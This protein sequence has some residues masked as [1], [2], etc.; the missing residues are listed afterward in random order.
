MNFHQKPNIFVSKVALKVEDIE[1]SI[2]FYE[3]VI[4]FELL[5]RTKSI[6][7]LTADGETPLLEI[8]QPEYVTKKTGQTTGL[9][10][11]AL[12]LPNRKDLAKMLH[13]FIKMDISLGSSDHHVSEALYLSDPDG[14]G[15]EIYTDRSPLLWNWEDGTVEMVS[16]SLNIHDLLKE[17]EGEVWKGLPTD[18]IMGHIHLHVADLDSTK[19]FYTNGLGMNIVSSYH[20]AL[21]ISSGGYHHHIA[22]NTWAGENVPVPAY[23]E[24]GLKSYTLTYPTEEARQ[25]AFKELTKLNAWIV[26]HEGNYITKDPSGNEIYLVL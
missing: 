24:V 26:E 16:V 11:F 13:H 18:T 23:N 3:R 10:H 14:N 2:L 12:L 19:D 25:T 5:S 21:F 8:E 7:T 20:K 17:G 6:A 9:Y 4:G 22:I 1:R 15:I